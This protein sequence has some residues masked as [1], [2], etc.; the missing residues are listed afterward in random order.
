MALKRDTKNKVI[1]GVCA[2]IANEMG[3]DPLIV[4]MAFVLAVLLGFGSGILIYLLM[5]I[6]MPAE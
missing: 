1:A 6:L 2:G 4:R 5:L 3:I